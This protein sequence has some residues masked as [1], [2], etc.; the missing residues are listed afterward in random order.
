MLIFAHKVSIVRGQAG[1]KRLGFLAGF[2]G[3]DSTTGDTHEFAI[4]EFFA[5]ADIAVVVEEGVGVGLVEF[6]CDFCG[7]FADGHEVVAE[8]GD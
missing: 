4:D 8:W 2:V 5:G 6:V 1:D 7:G 3:N